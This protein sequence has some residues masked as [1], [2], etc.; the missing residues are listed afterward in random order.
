MASDNGGLIAQTLISLLLVIAL[1]AGLAF[2]ARR[3]PL[4]SR[5]AV[6]PMQ[7][8]SAMAVSPRER[9]LVVRVGSQWLIVG[10]TASQLN[11]LGHVPPEDRP[12][13]S[14]AGGA[15]P[16]GSPADMFKT[17]LAGRLNADKVATATP[18]TP[19]AKDAP[20]TPAPRDGAGHVG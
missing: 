3:S 19:P 18:N 6:I 1:I 20:L 5:H 10:Q 16:S 8:I 7:L 9:I 13:P 17:L 14:A 2:W 12:A 4:A 11:L 15:Q